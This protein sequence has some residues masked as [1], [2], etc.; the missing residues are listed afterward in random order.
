[1]LLNKNLVEF[2][3]SRAK[4]AVAR[5]I[6]KPGFM[7]SGREMA[8]LCGVSHSWVITLLKEFEEI[9]FI[10]SRRVGKTVIWTAKT[11]SYAYLAAEKLFGS[12]QLFK[13]ITHLKSMIKD[14]LKN[15][16]VKKAVIFGSVAEEAEDTDS[17]IDLFVLVESVKEKKKAEESLENLSGKCGEVFGNVLHFYILTESEFKQK[18][19]L[20]IMKNIRK[21]IT[22]I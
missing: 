3:D 17:D 14:G 12:Q 11:N 10:S 6:I 16:P 2:F 8:K 4:M 18:S 9:N 7:M 21:G 5:H 1:M 20:A 15:N 13:P 19:G 22:I